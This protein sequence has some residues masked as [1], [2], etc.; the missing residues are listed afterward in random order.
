M[1]KETL[2]LKGISYDLKKMAE[3]Q[4]SIIEEWRFI[5]ILS[6]AILG[7]CFIFP[8]WYIISAASFLACIYHIVRYVIEYKKYIRQIKAIF[9]MIDRGDICIYLEKFS[10]KSE[11]IIYEPHT[12]LYRK[13]SHGSRPVELFYFMSGRS[14][15]IPHS[16]HTH[17]KWSKDFYITS[18]GLF[19]IS[20]VGDEFYYIS[21]NGY[22]D[23]SYVYPCEQF[24]LDKSLDV[25]IC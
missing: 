4:I 17:Y 21:L 8:K 1:T 13:H 24:V 11:E 3:F 2:T 6:F 15:R 20:S 14:W 18:Q 19:N 23:I 9:K 25:N 22:Y 16:I 10:H 5:F 7:V 12:H